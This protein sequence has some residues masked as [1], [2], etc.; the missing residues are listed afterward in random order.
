MPVRLGLS[1]RILNSQQEAAGLEAA[2]S[3]VRLSY[4]KLSVISKPN[5]RAILSAKIMAVVP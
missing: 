3:L 4:K 2:A 1:F 5:S